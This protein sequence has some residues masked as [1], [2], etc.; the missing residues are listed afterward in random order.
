MDNFTHTVS[1]LMLSRAGLNRLSPYATLILATS[2]NAPDIDAV[3]LFGGQ[4][5]MFAYHRGITH[6][7]V[8]IPFIA[9]MVIA[10]V[11]ALRILRKKIPWM[12][13][14]WRTLAHPIQWGRASL[15]ALIGVSS[16]ILLDWTNPYRVRLFL[17]WS[18]VWFGLGAISVIDVWVW[19]ALLVSVTAPM[20]SRLIG[21]EIGAGKTTGRGW[22]FFFLLFLALYIPARYVLSKRAVDVQTARLYNGLTPRKV[23]VYPAQ[24]DPFWWYGFV[25]TDL[26]WVVQDVDLSKEFDPTKGRILFKP[27]PSPAIEAARATPSFQRLL[28]FSPGVYWE[29]LPDAQLE[30]ATLVKATDLR[31]GSREAD[32]YFAAAIVDRNGRVQRSWFQY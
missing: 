10:G 31:F 7:I 13:T 28:R 3:S 23:L 30:G 25:E 20:L 16:H 22:A 4:E 24:M 18:D 32:H 5:A 2:A 29:A 19:A 1:G 27:E 17:P 11:A 9:A 21:S 6:A 8:A 26:F 15:L 14:R 12:Q